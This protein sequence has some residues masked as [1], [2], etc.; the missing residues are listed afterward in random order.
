VDDEDICRDLACEI[1]RRAGYGVTVAADGAE[2]LSHLERTR[3]DVLVSDLIMP[4]CSGMD[5]LQSARERFPDLEVVILTGHGDVATAVQAI[6][7]GAFD[8]LTKP[9][10]AERLVHTV[11]QAMGHRRLLLQAFDLRQQLAIHTACGTLVG[12]D[13]AIVALRERICAVASSEANVLI[14]GETGTGKELVAKAIHAASTRASKPFV[15]V[16]CAALPENLVASEFFGHERGSFT[17]AVHTRVG[18]VEA[19]E[20][21]SL[22]LD[23]IGDLPVSAQ[24][25]LLRLLQERCFERVGSNRSI[26][27]DA[28]IIAATK[29]GLHHDVRAG[30]FR[31]DLYFRLDVVHLTCPPLRDRRGDIPL[32]V[33][34]FLHRRAVV[35]G[36]EAR[37]SP[38]SLRKL[39]CYPWPGNV[40]ELE[41]VLA[42]A[43]LL[44]KSR[45]IEPDDIDFAMEGMPKKPDSLALLEME[46]QHITHVLDLCNWNRTESARVLGVDR[47]TLQRKIAQF[48]LHA[49]KRGDSRADSNDS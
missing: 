25:T 17:T 28:R 29:R 31:E 20:G 23:E 36:S 41:N 46:R 16:N 1:L 11:S 13:R 3:P 15:A 27:M 38:A 39:M 10:E 35:E 19:A 37:L 6:R 40:R 32:L 24:G 45:L 5:L 42:R 49:A 30:T 47:G 9:F 18:R 33:D 2:A 48:D 34:Y 12:M 43:V 44:A 7:M 26:A 4:A 21:G 8:Y 22:F 14:M